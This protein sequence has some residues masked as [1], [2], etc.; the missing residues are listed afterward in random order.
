MKYLKVCQ[1]AIASLIAMC[2]TVIA[3]QPMDKLIAE[4]MKL[5]ASQYKLLARSVPAD[6][7]PRHYDPQKTSG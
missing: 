5:A 1:L 4:N 3:Q 7:M 2:T 6:S